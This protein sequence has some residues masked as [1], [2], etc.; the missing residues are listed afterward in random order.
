LLK[1]LVPLFDACAR[2]LERPFRLLLPKSRESDIENVID[3]LKFFRCLVGAFKLGK[4]RLPL[5]AFPK[6]LGSH[7]VVRAIRGKWLHV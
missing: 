1:L 4:V 5:S 7:A 2:R 3:L 6:D